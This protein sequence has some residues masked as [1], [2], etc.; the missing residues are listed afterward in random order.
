MTDRQIKV[1]RKGL[2]ARSRVQWRDMTPEEQRLNRELSCREMINSILCYHGEDGLRKDGLNYNEYLLPY[3]E[4]LGPD[5]VDRLCMEQVEDFR[6]AVVR[7]NVSVDSDGIS[8]NSIEWADEL[9]DEFLTVVERD[10]SADGPENGI[11]YT[12][13]NGEYHI[14]A[15]V[16]FIDD[17]R[18]VVLEPNKVVDGAHEPIGGETFIVDF[19]DTDGLR[20]G[21]DWCLSQFSLDMYGFDAILSSACERSA[22]SKSDNAPFRVFILQLKPGAEYAY[23]RFT[24]LKLLDGGVNSVVFES[25]NNVYSFTDDTGVA[26]DDDVSVMRLLEEVFQRFNDDH[27]SDFCG[28]SLSVSDVVVLKTADACKAFY[29]DSW[30]FEEL[31]QKF[32]DDFLK[33]LDA[34]KDK[35]ATEMEF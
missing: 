6:N 18:V 20:Q 13:P 29:C 27:P 23:E 30:G 12:L 34:N 31:P 35:A 14:F 17:D 21:C 33:D 10:L 5:V 8:Y 9:A 28:H 1:A 25:Y 4:E 7:Q 15:Y 24:P 26:I 16:D 19:G 32:A 11:G 2:P 3:V 22:V